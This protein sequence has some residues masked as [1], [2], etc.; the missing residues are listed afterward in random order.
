MANTAPKNWCRF[1][2]TNTHAEHDCPQLHLAASIFN[3]D[4]QPP[5]SEFLIPKGNEVVPSEYDTTL[6]LETITF[7]TAEEKED[8]LLEDEP[9]CCESLYPESA[10]VL[11]ASQFPFESENE[12]LNETEE[13]QAFQQTNKSHTYNLRNN[14]RP[15]GPFF[16]SPE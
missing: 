2:N 14:P 4:V 15:G 7:A 10:F 3:V 11:N 6:V 9:Y 12:I 8:E 5:T 16:H 1:H 13:V